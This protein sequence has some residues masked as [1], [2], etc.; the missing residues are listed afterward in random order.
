MISPTTVKGKQIYRDA[1]DETKGW[2]TKVSD[3]LKREWIKWSNQLKTAMVPRSVARGVG[4]VQAIPSHLKT[5]TY[6]VL[7][8]SH[9]LKINNLVF[10]VLEKTSKH[11]YTLLT[12]TKAKFRNNALV[13]KRDFNL[14]EEQLKKRLSCLTQ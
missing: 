11:Y 8:I 14:S 10:D 1:C 9:S 4:R 5:N 2:N 6:P 12:S 3:Q 13:L 7:E